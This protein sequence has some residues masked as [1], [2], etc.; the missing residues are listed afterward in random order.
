MVRPHVA[1]PLGFVLSWPVFL[2]V[3]RHHEPPFRAGGRHQFR[4]R[5]HAALGDGRRRRV[6]PRAVLA[7]RRT[8][9]RAR[10]RMRARPSGP[11]SHPGPPRAGAALLDV[12]QLQQ[13]LRRWPAVRRTVA[14]AQPLVRHR[15][16]V[17]LVRLRGHRTGRRVVP[18]NVS[19][20]PLRAGRKLLVVRQRRARA[21]HA[22]AG[23]FGALVHRGRRS[24]LR[25]ANSQE[26]RAPP[27]PAVP[28][29]VRVVRRQAARAH[30][31]G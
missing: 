18:R 5:R 28:R 8:G 2:R 30:R 31:P 13:R 23:L 24:I 4:P 11:A 15:R 29:G 17:S 25:G 27:Q 10:H 22:V 1:A 20:R 19:F 7:G 12:G 3:V 26:R 9:G 6:L 21:Q 14:G 16:V